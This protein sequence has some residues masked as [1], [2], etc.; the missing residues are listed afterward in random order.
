[1]NFPWYWA[2]ILSTTGPHW[3]KY[4]HRTQQHWLAKQE[5]QS[6]ASRGRERGSDRGLGQTR[7]LGQGGIVFL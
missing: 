5:T 6:V 4:R 1:M 2:Y 3:A 7:G